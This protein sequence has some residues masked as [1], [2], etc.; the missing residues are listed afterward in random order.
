MEK[1]FDVK[2]IAITVGT[3]FILIFAF[4]WI[5][6][7]I[8]NFDGLVG[9]LCALHIAGFEFDIRV[10]INFLYLFFRLFVIFVAFYLISLISLRYENSIKISSAII[11]VGSLLFIFSNI[12]EFMHEVLPMLEQAFFYNYIDFVKIIAF[13]M[14]LCKIYVKPSNLNDETDENSSEKN[15]IIGYLVIG[16]ISCVLISISPYL[17][18]GAIIGLIIYQ[19]KKIS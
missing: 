19:K 2:E 8:F 15:L 18:I 6:N 1:N 7:K 9:E 13:L 11:L 3:Y 16:Y 10:L 14:A 4:S 12:Y 17:F 5:G